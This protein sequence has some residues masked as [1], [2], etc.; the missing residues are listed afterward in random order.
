[1]IKKGLN[2][3]RRKIT[4]HKSRKMLTATTRMNKRKKSPVRVNVKLMVRAE[5]LVHKM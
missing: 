3:F 5:F 4:A 2:I 1:L